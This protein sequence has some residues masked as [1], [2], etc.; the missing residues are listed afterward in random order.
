MAVDA[1]ELTTE[2]AGLDA[3][4]T[5]I[6]VTRSFAARLWSR[7]W[8]KLAALALVV[9]IWQA[10]VWSHW[11]PE[12]TFPGPKT[13]GSTLF[14]LVK[15]GAFWRAVLRTA[16]RAIGGY[17]ASVV[18]GGVLGALVAAVKPLRTAVGA[19]I[20]GLQTMPSIVWF[21]LAVLL[22]KLSESAIAFVVIMGAAPA[23][24]NGL[25]NGIDHVPPLLLRA[26]RVLGAS[27]VRLFRHVILPAALP[28]VL[29]G[30]KQ[31]WAFAWRSLMAAELLAPT[32]GK[33]LGSQLEF[34]RNNNDAPGLF[35]MMVVLLAVG[36]L[37][38]S[39]FG[40]ADNALRR[41]WGLVDTATAR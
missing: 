10:V 1:A 34:A 39:G 4:E 20:T 6:R 41:R 38:D 3:L 30:L 37:V 18:I 22:F 8:P 19:L 36:L 5:D 15:T 21:P 12:Y 25:I 29:G 2:L 17:A 24:A 28:S 23:I 7:L 35:A 14:D 13:V 16:K 26:G 33:S 11:R 27:G 31:A 32:L 9:G 40:A